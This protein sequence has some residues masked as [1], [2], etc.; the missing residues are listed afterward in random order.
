MMFDFLASTYTDR[1]IDTDTMPKNAAAGIVKYWKNS[2][3][4]KEQTNSTKQQTAI[5]TATDALE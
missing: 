5:R 2:G 1:A 3:T 4:K